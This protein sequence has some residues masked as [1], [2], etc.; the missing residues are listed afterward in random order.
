[1]LVTVSG[2]EQDTD[3]DYELRSNVLTQEFQELFN[4]IVIGT[5]FNDAAVINKLFRLMC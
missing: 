4:E 1:M 5:W 3:D 2:D